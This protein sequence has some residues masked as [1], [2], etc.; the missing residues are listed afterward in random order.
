MN[1]MCEE[2]LGTS[3]LPPTMNSGAVKEIRKFKKKNTK[4]L[5]IRYIINKWN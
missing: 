2:R 1:G 3:I 5:F 4:N